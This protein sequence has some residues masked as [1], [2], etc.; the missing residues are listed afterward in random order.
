[1]ETIPA[2]EGV[3]LTMVA[4]WTQKAELP[5]VMPPSLPTTGEVNIE[6]KRQKRFKSSD[7]VDLQETQTLSCPRR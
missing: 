6:S 7:S 3:D 4:A 1:M 5:H 2:K